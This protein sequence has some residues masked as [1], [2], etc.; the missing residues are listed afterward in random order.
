MLPE[1]LVRRGLGVNQK[2]D[3]RLHFIPLAL[4][5]RNS[6]QDVFAARVAVEQRVERSRKDG[7]QTGLLAPAALAQRLGQ[8]RADAEAPAGA[9]K[10]LHGRPRPIGGQLEQLGRA[11]Q[12]LLPEVQIFGEGRFVHPLLLPDGVISVLNRQTACG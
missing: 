2:A 11:A 4:A 7:E 6:E 5:E 8:G 9:T 3:H 10:R 12:V 1:S